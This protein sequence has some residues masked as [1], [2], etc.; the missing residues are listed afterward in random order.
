[1][2]RRE[3]FSKEARSP[4]S[5]DEPADDP[6]RRGGDDERAVPRPGKELLLKLEVPFGHPQTEDAMT[7]IPSDHLAAAVSGVP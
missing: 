4:A 5:L 6:P 1:M 3:A 7:V 2:K